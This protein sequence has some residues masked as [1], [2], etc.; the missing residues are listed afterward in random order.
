[1]SYGVSIVVWFCLAAREPTPA[2]K[3]TSSIVRLRIVLRKQNDE[4]RLCWAS[5]GGEGL[6]GSHD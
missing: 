3:T 5:S 6:H 1:M 2:V 4:F